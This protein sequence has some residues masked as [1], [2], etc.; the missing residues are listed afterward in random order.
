MSKIY[1]IF[2]VYLILIISRHR[3]INN[4]TINQV[5]LYNKNVIEKIN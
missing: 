2:R 5:Y 4:E 1:D 3:P